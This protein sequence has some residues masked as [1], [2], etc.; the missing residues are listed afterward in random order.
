MKTETLKKRLREQLNE[1]GL[2]I[3]IKQLVEIHEQFASEC[4]SNKV[5]VDASQWAEE[6]QFAAD[7]LKKVVVYIYNHRSA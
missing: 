3:L 4:N 1:H 6:Y 7:A 2:F 5:A